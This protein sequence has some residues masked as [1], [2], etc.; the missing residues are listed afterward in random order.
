MILNEDREK[1]LIWI[2]GQFTYVGNG[3]WERITPRSWE[4]PGKFTHAELID[5]YDMEK[6][7]NSLC[8]QFKKTSR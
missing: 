8:A 4:K 5:A 6:A 1:L 7:L 2:T 3:F